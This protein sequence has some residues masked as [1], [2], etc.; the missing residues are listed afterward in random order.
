MYRL[1]KFLLFILGNLPLPFVQGL[2]SLTGRLAWRLLPARREVALVNAG[3]IGVD[4][5][6]K[7]AKLSFRYTFMSY[8]ETAYIHKINEAFVNKYVTYEQK[9]YF[10]ELVRNGRFYIISAHLGSWDLVSAVT[11]YVCNA[12]FLIVGRDGRKEWLNKFLLD[13]RNTD[14]VVYVS[15]KGYVEK[16]AE[17][18]KMGYISGSLLDHSTTKS[19]NLVAPFFGLRVP[20]F[21]AI[22]ALCVRKKMPMLP[23]YLLRTAK[24]FHV[25]IR[26]P[27]APDN[28]LKAKARIADLAT[29]MN[30][31]YETVI[32]LYP[33]QWYLLHKRFK[34]AATPDGI[35]RIHIYKP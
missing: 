32:R 22:A 35:E 7:T 14:R 26:P 23:V 10:D 15:D 12:K 34:K 13:T 8:F 6:V 33:E 29:R 2:G 25:L 9:E 24:G 1:L 31:E 28:N 16:I 27:I 3:I 18:E 5:P 20:T 11:S 21:A 30:M 19:D 17:Y 4:N